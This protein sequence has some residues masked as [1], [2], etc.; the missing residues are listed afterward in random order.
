[1]SLDVAIL[2]DYVIDSEKSYHH[3]DHHCLKGK[4]ARSDK[5]SLYDICAL[6]RLAL[7]RPRETT[8]L[9]LMVG[10]EQLP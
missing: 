5:I 4:T 6:K 2:S 10:I 9:A 8:V 7:T 3:R 1:M